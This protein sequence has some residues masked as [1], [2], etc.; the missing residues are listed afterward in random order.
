MLAPPVF[1]Q[2]LEQQRWERHITI[3]LAFALAN[4]DDHPL[5]IDVGSAQAKRFAQTKSGRIDRR[6]QDAVTRTFDRAEKLDSLLGRQHHGQ[7]PFTAG[8]ANALDDLRTG[9]NLAIEESQCGHGLVE[10]YVR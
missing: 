10:A 5:R 6:Q 2:Y 7:E 8:V 9:Q 3:L 1:A 4:T